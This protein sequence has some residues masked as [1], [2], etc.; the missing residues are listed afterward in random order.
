[1]HLFA[2]R[3][4]LGW[5]E[6]LRL[7]DRDDVEPAFRAAGAAGVGSRAEMSAWYR[8]LEA[9]AATRARSSIRELGDG[10]SLEVIEEETR[11]VQDLAALVEESVG[12][13]KSELRSTEPLAARVTVLA[14]AA[15]AP[16]ATHPGGYASPRTEYVKVCVPFASLFSGEEFSRTVAHEFAHVI[17]FSYAGDFAERWVEEGVAVLIEDDFDPIAREDFQSGDVEWLSWQELEEDFLLDG[18]TEEEEDAVWLAYQQSAW[19][20]RY[21]DELGGREELV[22]FL[23]CHADESIWTNV[24]SGMKGTTRSGRALKHVY[25]FTVQIAFSQT[26]EWLQKGGANA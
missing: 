20:I 7:Y 4:E 8:T 13:A 12:K 24:M 23:K 15:D 18:D 16:W 26:I 17:T 2:P 25:G 21:L 11:G 19:V 6:I 10:I 5:E 3:E 1:V 22:R 9:E 14:E